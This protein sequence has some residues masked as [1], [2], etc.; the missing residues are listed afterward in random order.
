MD[1]ISTVANSTE[2]LPPQLCPKIQMVSGDFSRSNTQEAQVSSLSEKVDFSFNDTAALVEDSSESC[3]HSSG[4]QVP[5]GIERSSFNFPED[6]LGSDLKSDDPWQLRRYGSM[7]ARL[8]Q[9]VQ[10]P[11]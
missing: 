3:K 11:D 4:E 1:S 10:I 9:N 5:G 2:H 8:L 6:I 7:A